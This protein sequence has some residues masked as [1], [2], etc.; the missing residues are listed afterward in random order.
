M[1]QQAMQQMPPQ[2]TPQQGMPQM[3]PQQAAP[4]AAAGAGVAAGMDF[5]QLSAVKVDPK[6]VVRAVAQ[7]AGWQLTEAGEEWNITVSVGTTRKQAVHVKFGAKDAEGHSLISFRSV[8]GPYTEQNAPL[9]LRF[10]TQMVAGAFAVENLG[11]GEMVVVLANQLADSASLPETLRLITAVAWQADK[12]E[13]Q[14][15]GGDQN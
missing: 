2:M 5:G 15:L 14:L 12:V 13:E 4:A 9:L 10:N 3:T 7:N 6:Q 1:M 11:S 8:C